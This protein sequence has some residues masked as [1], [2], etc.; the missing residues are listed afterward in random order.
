M[1]NLIRSTGLTA[2]L[3]LP[4]LTGCG[5]DNYDV[6]PKS[7]KEIDPEKRSIEFVI[8][9][10][11]SMGGVFSGGKL[12]DAKEVYSIVLDRLNEYNQKNKNLE[13]GLIEFSSSANVLVNLSPFGYNALKEKI[14][15]LSAGGG[16]AIGIALAQAEREVD[17]GN[18]LK[19]I[20]L[21]T[22]GANENGKSPEE[23]YQ[24]II[25][26][27]NKSGDIT[28]NLYIIA[29]DVDKKNFAELEKLGAKV[30]EAKTAQDLART[31]TES[32][33]MALEGK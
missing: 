29:F 11:G 21:L 24:N 30:Y 8:D 27:N 17:T 33:D 5:N 26:T 18:G 19:S 22:D 9:T 16:T 10:S 7:I 6:A 4:A 14:S 32:L 23:I 31:L 13:A 15:G 28:T 3:G 25:D 2:L 20:V 12:K 1:R